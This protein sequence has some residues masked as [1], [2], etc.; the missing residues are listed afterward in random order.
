MY[1]DSKWILSRCI[2]SAVF[3][4]VASRPGCPYVV[5][6]YDH[7][8]MVEANVVKS[9]GKCT[10]T[11]TPWHFDLV[12]IKNRSQ[13]R[14]TKFHLWICSQN[15]LFTKF[16]KKIRND[17]H[18]R[19]RTAKGESRSRCPA[20]VV[21]LLPLGSTTHS[22]TRTFLLLFRHLVVSVCYHRPSNADFREF[23]SQAN[24][25]QLRCFS[26]SSKGGSRPLA[27]VL[28]PLHRDPVAST[29]SKVRCKKMLIVFSVHYRELI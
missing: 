4:C 6:V 18:I 21:S 15:V 11:W 26:A 27:P 13:K 2:N 7:L 22:H 1:S 24:Q 10:A 12:W 3:S 23:F 20:H 16:M 19:I 29:D 17:L 5:C 9:A 14:R 25:R 28:W 8:K